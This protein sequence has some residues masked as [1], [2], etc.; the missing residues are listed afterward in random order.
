MSFSFALQ[1][2]AAIV[3]K[4]Y[5]GMALSIVNICYLCRTSVFVVGIF[6]SVI[7]AV[8]ESGVTVYYRNAVNSGSDSPKDLVLFSAVTVTGAGLIVKFFLAFL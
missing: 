2:K 3:G 1:G 6:Y 8:V 7:S 4:V 5:S